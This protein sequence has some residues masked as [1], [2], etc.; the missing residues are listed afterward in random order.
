MLIIYLVTGLGYFFNWIHTIILLCIHIYQFIFFAAVMF[1][2]VI[3]VC[4]L[5]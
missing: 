2:N 5:T 1:V 4:L 3:M